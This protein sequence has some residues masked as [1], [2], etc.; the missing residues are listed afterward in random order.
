M[1]RAT[2]IIIPAR[3]GTTRSSIGQN[4]LL[5]TLSV[6]EI[7]RLA[8]GLE[9]VD[10]PLGQPLHEPGGQM[11]HAYFPTT[12]IASLHYVTAS[13][14]SAEIAGVGHEGMV[15][16]ALFL[17]GDTTPN[18]ASVRASGQAYRIRQGLL[19]EEFNRHGRLHRVLLR[20]TMSLMAQVA[21]AAACNRHHTVEQRLCT[22]LLATLDRAPSAPIVLTQDLIAGLLGVRREGVTEAAGRLQQAGVIHYRRG[23]ITV[24]ERSGLEAGACECYAAVAAEL[25]RLLDVEKQHERSLASID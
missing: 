22:C 23:H 4:D 2:A 8:P 21:Q 17:G 12:C 18:A 1:H 24:R 14:S 7:D 11:S 9:L 3:H 16:I 10:L 13:G 20:Y 25:G 6:D 5:A 19:A 15:G